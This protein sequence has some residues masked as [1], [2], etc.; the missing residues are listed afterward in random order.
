MHDSKARSTGYWLTTSLAGLNF[1]IAGTAY[2]AGVQAVRDAFAELG[3]PAYLVPFLGACKLLGGLALLAPRLPR[4]KEW[5]YA[6]ITCNL[7]GAAASHAAT[8]HAA[9]KVIA[10]LLVLAVVLAS[11]SLRPASRRLDPR[12]EASPER[13]QPPAARAQPG[14]A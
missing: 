5:A 14:V 8:G 6:G 7:I 3:Y 4:L 9:T 10:P 12:P 11:W 2:L 1:L 13:N